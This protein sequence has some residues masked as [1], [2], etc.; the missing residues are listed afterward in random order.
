MTVWVVG[1]VAIYGGVGGFDWYADKTE[2]QRG[3][4]DTTALGHFD[5]RLVEL[6]VPAGLTAEGTTTWLDAR[7]E[8]WEPWET[9][10]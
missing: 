8:L 1:F 4:R 9:A 6:E 10:R 3:Y 7:P 2:A 5:A